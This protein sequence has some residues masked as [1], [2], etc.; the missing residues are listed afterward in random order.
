MKMKLLC[1]ATALVLTLPAASLAEP[2][3]FA[4]PEEGADA[5]ITAL[6]SADRDAVLAVF[7]PESEDVIIS[8]DPERNREDREDF[9]AAWDDLHRVAVQEDG[10]ARI[11]VGRD[12]HPFAIA[13]V[14]T[15]K[16]WQFDVEG[17]REELID[18]RIGQNELDVIELMQ[19]YVLVQ[20]RFRETDWDGDGVMEFAHHILSSAEALDGLY[21]PPAEGV[22][23]SLIGD[24]VARAAAQGYEI[25][26]EVVE[27]EP[28]LGYYFH[29]LEGQGEGA[30][31]GAF[32]Y[33]VNDNMVAGH[34]LIAFPAA[35]GETGVMSFMVSENGVIFE[36]DL[37][38]DTIDAASAI[39]L[40]DPSQGWAEVDEPAN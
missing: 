34:A 33:L 24:A 29:I 15:D 14:E 22:P 25:G 4:T 21:W 38:D 7:G 11:Y 35:H 37:G 8:D 39:E 5:L 36:Q 28:Y 23:E 20:Q 31:G 19:A 10:S 40:F 3:S 27:P 12:R 16:G 30:P 17:G 18:R 6:R 26:G 2:Q 1:A 9:I 13:L 32:G